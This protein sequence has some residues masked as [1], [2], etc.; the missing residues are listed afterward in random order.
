MMQKDKFRDFAPIKSRART[1][2]KPRIARG[3]HAPLLEWLAKVIRRVN[4]TSRVTGKN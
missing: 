4:E 3:T 2:K 1:I